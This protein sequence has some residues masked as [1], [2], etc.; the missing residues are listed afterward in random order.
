M[1]TRMYLDE[2]A[3]DKDFEKQRKDAIFGPVNAMKLRE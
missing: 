3:D 2:I 1:N